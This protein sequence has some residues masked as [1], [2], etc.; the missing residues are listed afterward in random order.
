[1][2]ALPRAVHRTVLIPFLYIYPLHHIKHLVV[3]VVVSSVAL[4]RRGLLGNLA[5]DSTCFA[6]DRRFLYLLYLAWHAIFKQR[7]LAYQPYLTGWIIVESLFELFIPINGSHSGL[8]ERCR[9]KICERP[10]AVKNKM[11]RKLGCSPDQSL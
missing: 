3:F 2:L 5:E 9:K 7:C 10:A 6:Y 4:R 1:M 8:S 11:R